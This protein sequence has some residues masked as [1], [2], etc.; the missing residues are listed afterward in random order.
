MLMNGCPTTREL[1]RDT[2]H[3]HVCD[4]ISNIC[5]FVSPK[6]EQKVLSLRYTKKWG[7]NTISATTMSYT[8]ESRRGL[9]VSWRRR[10]RQSFSCKKTCK[11]TYCSSCERLNETSTVVTKSQNYLSFFAF[12]LL[13]LLFKNFCCHSWVI[14]FG[15]NTITS[16]VTVVVVVQL[17]R[18]LSYSCHQMSLF[19]V[20]AMLVSVMMKCWKRLQ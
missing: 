9:S 1:T 10:K 8:E 11:N 20:S 17:V 2:L 16:T 7:T 6:K 15:T 3:R 13:C 14:L 18:R 4:C 5:C 19:L 12:I